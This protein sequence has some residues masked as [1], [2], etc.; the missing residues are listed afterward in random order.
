[1]I[2]TDLLS[3]EEIRRTLATEIVG[4][5]IFLFGTV[6]STNTRLRT[7]ARNGARAG[8]VVL[9]EEQTAGQGRRGQVW[10]SPGGVNLYVSVLLRPRLAARQLGAFSFIASLALAD[11]VKELGAHPAIK[12]PNDVLVEGKKIGGSLVECAIRDDEV[13]YVILGVGVNLNVEEIALRAAL[14]RS[15]GFA[16][17]LAAA[18][19]HEIDRNAFA[20][21]YLNHLDCWARTWELQGADAIVKA[22]RERDILIGRRVDVRG[23]VA[24]VQGWVTGVAATGH[25]VVRDTGGRHRVLASEEVRLV[26]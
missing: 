2:A 5:H 24:A 14:G 9:A 7:L 12:W 6:E 26:D 21:A 11:A 15:A 18:V 19:G 23:P 22:W 1:M 13:D 16:T 20:A 17:S 25:L 3:I 10:F 8:T 4:R